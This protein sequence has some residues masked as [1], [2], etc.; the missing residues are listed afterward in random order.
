MNTLLLPTLLFLAGCIYVSGSSSIN[1]NVTSFPENVTTSVPVTQKIQNNNPLDFKK[2][3]GL[4]FVFVASFCGSVWLFFITFF[5]SRLTGVIVT[6]LL[7]KF[8]IADDSY[9]K[10][11]KKFTLDSLGLLWN[12]QFWLH[13][14]NFNLQE[15]FESFHTELGIGN[16]FLIWI[17]VYW[18][19]D[20]L[21][22]ILLLLSSFWEDHVQRC[23][24]YN[25]RLQH[26]VAFI[27]IQ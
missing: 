24:V 21:S 20:Q 19:Y 2:Y 22:R 27:N 3:P 11:G 4:V 16:I 14:I 7:N 18:I 23:Q 6:K 8:F 9:V 1:I 12:W 13:F 15:Q 26:Q 17:V 10:L 25:K 5:N